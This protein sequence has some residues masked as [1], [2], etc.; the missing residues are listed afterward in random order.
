MMIDTHIHLS[1]FSYN[2]EFPYLSLEDDSYT[3]QRGTREQL[4]ERFK[5]AGIACCIDPAVDIES[6]R[7]LLSLAERF[8]GF[9]FSAVGVHPTRT[10]HYKVIGKDGKGLILKLP[11][12]QR[13]QL[14]ELS[15][16]PS[17]VAIGE[18]GL[19][20]HLA[21]KEQHRLRQKMW[22]IYQLKLAHKKKLPVILHIREADSDAIWILKRY[23][24][25]LHGGVCH[26]FSGS[27][28]AANC[29]TNLGLKLGIGGALL[30]DT[31]K[32]LAFEQA[33]ISTSLENFLLET[34]GPYVKPNCPNFQ[35]KQMKKTR[36]S[37]MILPAVAK[38]VAE[39][40]NVPLEEVLQVTSENTIKLF[41]LS[42][43]AQEFS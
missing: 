2:G 9:L 15:D 25:Y 39:L 10:Y 41:G 22:F 37:S 13:R 24:H 19:D 21:R 31:P 43:K 16:H 27:P 8:P 4:I 36:N 20:Y 28:E 11:W 38:R 6:N 1:H 18:T 29:Y 35:K 14:E 32:K 3:I 12:K 33:V 40:K 7:N 26:C 42:N 30:M 5:A 17:V 23:K 34:D